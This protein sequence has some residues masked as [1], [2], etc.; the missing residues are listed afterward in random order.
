MTAILPGQSLTAARLNSLAVYT[1][2]YSGTTDASGF[3][4]VSHGAPWAPTGG[5]YITTNPAASFAQPWGIDNI[6]A[7]QCRLRLAN[8]AGTGALANSAVQGRLFLIK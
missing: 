3:L 8:A 2:T 6:T 7:T 1:V 5:W 4:T